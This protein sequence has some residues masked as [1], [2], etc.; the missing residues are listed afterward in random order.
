MPPGTGGVRHEGWCAIW[1]DPPTL[2]DTRDCNCGAIPLPHAPSVTRRTAVDRERV[3]HLRDPGVQEGMTVQ[4]Q[5]AALWL[6]MFF[7]IGIAVVA[8]VIA[9]GAS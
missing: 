9:L 6:L 1:N 7:A 4:G 3:P 5:L 8:L 2:Q